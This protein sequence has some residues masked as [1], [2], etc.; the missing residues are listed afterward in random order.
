MALVTLA[1]GAVNFRSRQEELEIRS[2]LDDSRIDRL[3][4]AW[5]SGPTI[6]LVFGGEQRQVTAGAVIDPGL[7]IVMKRVHKRAFGIF[8]PQHAIRRSRQLLFPFLIG[9][10]DFDNRVD[11]NF[12]WHLSPPFYSETAVVQSTGPTDSYMALERKR[13]LDLSAS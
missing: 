8:V 3:P 2:S 13:R 5:P 4:K 1:A 11:L 7:V 9:P 10:S 6:E 12:R